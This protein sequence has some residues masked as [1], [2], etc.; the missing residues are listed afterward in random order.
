MTYVSTLKLSQAIILKVW[1]NIEPLTQTLTVPLITNTE[2]VVQSAAR[3]ISLLPEAEHNSPPPREKPKLFLVEQVLQL[4]SDIR[5]IGFVHGTKW[6]SDV[7]AEK[8]FELLRVSVGTHSFA[9]IN[10][11]FQCF[12]SRAASLTA[13][14]S[15]LLLNPHC[16]GTFY[17]RPRSS[18]KDLDLYLDRAL[19]PH[20]LQNMR[21]VCTSPGWRR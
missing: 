3:M 7:F 4:Y 18:P 16:T 13:C 8:G 2:T 21:S 19:C 14:L 9:S 12:R 20:L 5:M 6:V 1:H 17:C 11:S 10:S 15:L